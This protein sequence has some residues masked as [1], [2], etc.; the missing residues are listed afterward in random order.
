[1]EVKESIWK[2]GVGKDAGAKNLGPCHRAKRRVYAKKE[3][4]ILTIER[5]KRGS[6]EIHR[7][8]IEERIHPTLQITPNI[9]STLC[10]KKG[11]HMEDGAG[12]LTLKPVDNKE[13][14]PSTPHCRYIGWC[15]KEEGVYK[16]RLEMGIQ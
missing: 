7:R 2:K 10:G 1:M 8:P 14:I 15:R 12:L 11:W 4:G 5:R 9:T 16:I 13:W 6:T 3:K